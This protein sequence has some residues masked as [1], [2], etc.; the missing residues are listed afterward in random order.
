MCNELYCREIILQEFIELEILV[1]ELHMSLK[2]RL[3]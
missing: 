2:V 1:F 3:T